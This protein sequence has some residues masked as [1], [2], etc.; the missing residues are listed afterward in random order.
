MPAPPPLAEA[1]P[2]AKG[3]VHI[4]ISPW[5][6]V[7]VDGAAVGTAPPLTRLDLPQGTHTITVR[8]ADFPPYTQ[9]VQVDPDRPA[10]LKHRF[11]S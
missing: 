1:P 11:G 2:P 3:Q 7:E 10:T 6:Q 5:G 4:A 9:R 8:N